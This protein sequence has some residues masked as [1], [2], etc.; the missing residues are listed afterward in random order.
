MGW[1]NNVAMTEKITKQDI[2]GA[3]VGLL[4]RGGL[5]TLAMRR[6][7]N[8]LGIQQSALYWHFDNKQQLLA[9]VADRV[10]EPVSTPHGATWSARTEALASLLRGELLRYPDGA[11]LVATTIAFRLGAQRPLQELTDELV[12][13]GLAPEDA[14]IAASVIL[15]FVLGYATDE[16]QHRQAAALGAIE[17][18]GERGAELSA[19]ERFVSGVRLILSG[20]EAKIRAMAESRTPND[21]R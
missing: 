17:N 3:A 10:V 15:H 9:A 8:E 20:V 7:A 16:Q 11:E 1:V 21:G 19:D 5:H 13:A 2:V 4:A 18:T 14:G 12:S 6:I